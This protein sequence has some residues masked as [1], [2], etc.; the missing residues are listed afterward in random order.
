MNGYETP[1][2]ASGIFG[3]Y[4]SP[5]NGHGSQSP[6]PLHQKAKSGA[7]ALYEQR[8]HVTKTSINSLTDTSQYQVEHLSSFIVDRK[9][10]LLSV[11]DGVRRLRLLEAKGKVWTQEM[12]L[13]VEERSVRLLDL[14]TQK[15][16]EYFPVSSLLQ[17]QAVMNSCSFDSLLALVVRETGQSKPDLHLFQCDHIKANLIQADIES[18]VT[19]AKGGKERR[20]PEALRMILKSGRKE[21]SRPPGRPGPMSSKTVRSSATSTR[22]TRGGDTSA[23]RVDRDVQI[24]NHILDDVEF[25][26]MKLQKSTEAFSELSKRKKNKKGKKKGPG[27]GVLTLRSKP[28]S[29]EEFVD[30]LQKFKQAFNQLGKL[31]DNIQNPSAEDLLHFLFSPLRMVVQSAGGSDLPRSVLGWTKSRLEWPKEHYFPPFVL[32]FRDGW[33]PPLLPTAISRENRKR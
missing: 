25:F 28:P 9:D 4:G 8:K 10:G 22:R 6:E 17:V 11:E 32:T 13:Q 26:V 12:I 5:T 18:A 31:R 2:L 27:E 1:P 19:D 24:L 30:C 21:P 20:R 16:L 29:E 3:S 14:D 7:K 33:E 23:A 15:D